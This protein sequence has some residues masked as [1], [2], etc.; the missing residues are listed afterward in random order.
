L[1][2]KRKSDLNSEKINPFDTRK[3]Q[4]EQY[5]VKFL[6]SQTPKAKA[7][8]LNNVILKNDMFNQ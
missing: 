5:P 3:E 1:V 6:G 2:K 4:L 7:N 8:L